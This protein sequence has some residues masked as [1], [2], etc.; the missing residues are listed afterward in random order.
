MAPICFPVENIFIAELAAMYPMADPGGALHGPPGVRS[1]DS[2]WFQDRTVIPTKI[3]DTSYAANVHTAATQLIAFSHCLVGI[4]RWMRSWTS[5][6]TVMLIAED[7]P[8]VKSAFKEIHRISQ[9]AEKIK[10][11]MPAKLAESEELP[12]TQIIDDIHFTDKRGSAPLQI[13]DVC[14]FSI[15]RHLMKKDYT[16]RFYGHLR[17]QLIWKASAAAFAEL[18]S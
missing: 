14:A 12:G 9:S 13:A 6:E 10:H 8:E 1:S 4:E 18:P 11:F 15:K 3:N 5:E 2:F 17:P 16:Y 7:K